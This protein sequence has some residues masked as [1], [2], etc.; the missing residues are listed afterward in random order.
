MAAVAE[1]LLEALDSLG[2]SAAFCVSG[3]EEPI[4]PGLEV[5]GVGPVGVPVSPAAARQL[6]EHA[7]QAPY[8]RGEETIVD[9]DVRRV[10]QIEP[11]QFTLRNPQWQ[12]LVEGILDKVKAEFGIKGRVTASLYKL[13]IYEKG[14]F[15]APHRDTEK[16]DGMFATLIVC[17]PSRHEGGTLVVSHDRQS[18]E[19]EFGGPQGEYKVQYA[20]FYTDCR[21]EI[22]PVTAGYRVCLVYN[23]TLAR[24][25]RQPAAPRPGDKVGQVAGLLGRLFADPTRQKVAIP[26]KHEYTEA[27]LSLDLL[28][29]ADRVLVDVLRQAAQE[30][31]YHFYLALM[32]YRQVGDVDYDTVRYSRRGHDIDE[33]TAEMGEVYEEELALDHWIDAE[34]RR[35]A[36]GKMDLGAAEILSETDFEDFPIKQD[37]REATGNEGATVER[38]YRQAVV[39]LWPPDRYFALLAR[40]GQAAAIPVLEKL[41]GDVKDPSSDERCR[42][43]AREIIIRW[44][45][46]AYG[47]G[48]SADAAAML[49]LLGRIADPA[50]AKQF[51]R[52]VLPRAYRGT[53]GPALA[54]LADRLGWE[55]LAGELTGFVAAQQ[56]GSQT[57]DLGATVAVV[58]GLCCARGKMAPERK[59]VC[60]AVAAELE[61]TIRQWDT[62]KE[63]PFWYRARQAREG[64][65]ESLTR[66]LAAVGEGELL[67]RF[68]SHAL[69]DQEH[70]GL[71]QVLIPAVKKMYGWATKD[72]VIVH[73]R[74]QILRDCIA[75]LDRLTEKPVEEPRDWAQ[76]ITLRCNCVDCRQLQQFLR[77]PQEKVRRFPAAEARRRHLHQ[78]IEIHGCDMTH[79]TE[80]KGSPYTLVCT[81]NRASYE[82]K[83]AEFATNVQLL[84]ELRGLE[85]PKRKK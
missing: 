53:E 45:L 6:I 8:G 51:L 59:A 31:N 44:R 73:T 74:Q 67:G 3:S 21:H 58:E 81:K 38:W 75:E 35:Q 27:G 19:I 22:R 32:T 34:G 26:L 24:R 10:W 60:R 40:Q 77:D 5:Q 41:L 83:K 57:A 78:Q 9:T 65:I 84:K 15:F 54:R 37:V 71:H 66:T 11:N 62:E 12:A 23:L 56:P 46:L 70:Y 36:L 61:Q 49:K 29:G 25:K 85:R 14:N 63:T 33:D 76:D 69:S 1:E 47:R 30:L 50:L 79:V 7:T 80:R 28:K 42:A 48:D 72:P 13:L 55:T 43:F 68:L 20:A 16:V 64:V 18:K 4:L 39:V 82:R 17:L 52:D 2:E